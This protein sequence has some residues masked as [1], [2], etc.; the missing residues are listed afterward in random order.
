MVGLALESALWAR[1][2]FGITESGEKIE[3][4]DPNWERLVP[5]ARAAKENPAAWLAM[6]DIYGE[7]GRSEAFAMEFSRFLKE[8]W[9]N[10]VKK[11]ITNYL[12]QK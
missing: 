9:Q 8:L 1:Y 3:A 5:V 10:G 6:E 11:T 12:Q 7:L 4:N 2:C